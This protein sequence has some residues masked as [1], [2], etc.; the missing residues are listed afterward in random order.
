[1]AGTTRQVLSPV[2]CGLDV[3]QERLTACLRRVSADGHLTTELRQFGTTSPALLALSDWLVAQPC[4]V[5]A[6]ERTGVYWKP[7]YHVLAGVGE[8]VVGN[9]HDMRPRPGKKTDKADA[10][11]IAELLAQGLIR[12]RFV[13]PPAIRALRDLPRTRV[14]FVQTRTQAKNRGQKVLEDSNIKRASVASDVCGTSG[15]RMLEA[16]IAGE[17]DAQKLASMAR[18]RLRRKLPERERA[19]TGQ[20][21]AHHGRMIALALE[22]IDLLARQI[23]DLNEQIGLLVAPLQAHIAQLDSMP[24]V[25][26]TA[27]RDILGEMGTDMRRFGSAARLS[28]WAR[29]SPGNNERAGKRRPGRTGK[30]HRSLRRLLVQG[31]WAARKTP[32]FLGCTLRRLAARI[33]GK[34]AAVAIGHKMLVLVYHLLLAG[35]CYE[36]QRY[37]DQQPQ[38]EERERKRAIK[39]LDRLGY[40][41][42]VERVA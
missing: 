24:G 28:S 18:G 20:C 34:R 9:A 1:M 14:G 22:L 31:A 42:T 29:M 21:T 6:M 12:P 7:G 36:A 8:V 23:A 3:H 32:T 10:R 25:D 17:C 2:C 5:V 40:S 39:A 35:T 19:L 27:A 26:G 38:Q 37:A 13:P 11:W 30:G 41:V 4:P 33:G 16:L 15:R